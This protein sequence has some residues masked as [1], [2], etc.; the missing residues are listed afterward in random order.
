M[1]SSTSPDDS[2]PRARMSFADA[3]R[4]HPASLRVLLQRSCAFGPAVDP[5]T[6]ALFF[7]QGPDAL[8]TRPSL[9]KKY[10]D[11]V[12]LYT[13]PDTL[14]YRLLWWPSIFGKRRVALAP[15][16]LS[17]DLDSASYG[18]DRFCLAL[19]TS[20]IGLGG[21]AM[22]ELW[23]NIFAAFVGM[24]TAF[25]VFHFA[26]SVSARPTVFSLAGSFAVAIAVWVPIRALFATR[27]ISRSADSSLTTALAQLA[28]QDCLVG[29]GDTMTDKVST[30][31]SVSTVS[32]LNPGD[33][34][35]KAFVAAADYRG[36][37]CAHHRGVRELVAR[38]VGDTKTPRYIKT[39][40]VWLRD[41]I[42]GRTI[43]A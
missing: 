25:Y 42:Y 34:R 22:A 27:F 2:A 32:R 5:S 6:K 10:H 43:S 11:T 33:I 38:P 20:E 9:R 18:Y 41:R 31:P 24:G 14:P 4:I 26:R 29:V 12:E 1:S 40:M 35:R 8:L 39:V 37:L 15:D 21:T 36:L 7:S 30:L 19:A 13:M 16:F 17:S 3:S 23:T 28:C